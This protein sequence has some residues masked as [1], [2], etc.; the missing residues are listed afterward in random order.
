MFHTSP[1]RS[2]RHVAIA[3]GVLA[4]QLVTLTHGLPS[5]AANAMTADEWLKLTDSSALAPRQD[6][7]PGLG[8]FPAGPLNQ[9]L[10]IISSLPTGERALDVVAK[11]LTPLQQ[12]LA[13]AA[14]IDTTREDLAQNAPCAAVTVV[15][16]RGTTE[17]G[18]VGLI[19]G[20]PFFDALRDQLG[21]ETLAVQG[22][23]YPATFAGFNRNGTDGVPS[24][25][26][27]VDQ[28]ATRC[29]D[30]KIVMAGYSQGALVVRSTAAALPAGTMAK[31]SS[32]VTFGDPRNPAPI[33]GA[34]G[35]TLILCQPNDAV[36]SGGFITVAHLTYGANATAAAAFVV[37][38]AHGA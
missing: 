5:P 36:C 38:K 1:I 2:I 23:A 24:M 27:F 21:A 32:V 29:P 25:T 34:N 13:A 26:A 20:P 10:R 6:I 17:P 28:A 19:A 9:F 22:V 33:A 16:A 30:T 3:L 7:P 14:G 12:G 8:Q 15:F 18:S 11:I 4:S 37:Q 31:V 35:K